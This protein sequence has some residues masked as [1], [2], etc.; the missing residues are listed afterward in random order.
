MTRAE[1]GIVTAVAEASGAG[2]AAA[3]L[4]EDAGRDT[5][6]AVLWAL[7]AQDVVIGGG[8]SLSQLA[9]LYAPRAVHVGGAGRGREGAGPRAVSVS[10]AEGAAAVDVAALRSALAARL[11]E[12]CGRCEEWV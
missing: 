2:T 5:T 7:A 4:A 10:D 3:W 9:G 1:V 11:A 6:V 12:R 8:D